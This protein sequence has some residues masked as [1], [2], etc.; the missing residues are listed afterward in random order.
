MEKLTNK[1]AR[2]E[3]TPEAQVTCPDNLVCLLVRVS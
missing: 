2:I 1:E 3:N